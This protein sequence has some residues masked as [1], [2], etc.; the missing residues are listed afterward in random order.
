ML[1]SFFS[2][3]RSLRG[4]GLDWNDVCYELVRLVFLAVGRVD[5]MM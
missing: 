4:L 5:V 3:W 1:A 2:L